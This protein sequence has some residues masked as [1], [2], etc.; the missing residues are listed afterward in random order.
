MHCGHECA[1]ILIE[2]WCLMCFRWWMMW[3]W[4]VCGR[5]T[6]EYMNW[7]IILS[8][9]LVTMRNVDNDFEFV[10]SC[11]VEC[12]VLLVMHIRM[13]YLCVCVYAMLGCV[14]KCC[15]CCCCWLNI[16]SDREHS[17]WHCG[18]WWTMFACVWI[19]IVFFFKEFILCVNIIITS[20]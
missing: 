7:L 18:C 10:V 1:I 8:L 15:C 3:C 12:I 9:L 20:I 4:W 6:S 14:N 19:T 16:D 5:L 2:V 17:H 11:S 13:S